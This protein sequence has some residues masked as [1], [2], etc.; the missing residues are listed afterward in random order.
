MNILV[1]GAGVFG[2]WTAKFLADGGHTVT[3]VDAFGPANGRASSADHSRVIRAGYG[4]D[5]IY[6]RWATE[7][8]TEWQWLC[9]VSGQAL[10][11]RT[12]ALF[13]GEPDNAYVLDTHRTLGRLGL[14]VELLQPAQLQHRLPHMATEGLGVALFEP[15]AGVLRAR[16]SVQALV[17]VIVRSAGVSYVQ[18]QVEPV[19]EDAS[20]CRI[21]SHDGR[22][23][24]ADAH[25]FA[26]GPW[27]PK[28]LPHAVG[29]RIRATRQEVLYFG[30]PPGDARFSA[31]RM[32]V[33]IDFTAGVYGIPD[34]DALGFK[35]G[36]DRHGP[37]IDPD[38]ADRV[39]GPELV[40]TTR[41]WIGRRF[42]AMH[43]A[44][45]VDARVCQYENTSSG[46]FIVDRHPA[47]PTCWIVGGG[48]GHGFKHGPALGR[49][50]AALIA[51]S[52]GVRERF[53]LASKSSR[54]S[55]A[56]Y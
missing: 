4:A 26:C 16:A 39:V 53:R 17:G 31:S 28:L 22:E 37:S 13:M 11:A 25:V 51:G 56:V 21:H 8:L 43:N 40:E 30:V 44:P 6:S 10:L 29:P 50:V 54:A 18:A 48:S 46:D 23:F 41:Q 9:E 35:V 2:A 7:S 47:W 14:A 42:P 49:H 38:A 15:N 45:L 33:W 52:E 32:P 5:E 55:R 1:I 34:L 24:E 27:L 19:D 12:G 20:T 36:I 3:L